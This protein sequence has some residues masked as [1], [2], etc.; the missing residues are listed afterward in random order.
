MSKF[1]KN[2]V[3]IEAFQFT[4]EA[5][6]RVF[7]FVTCSTAA[8]FEDNQPI[9]KIQTPDGVVTARL[10]DWVIKEET[11]EFS[12]CQDQVFQQTYEPVGG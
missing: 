10:G 5:K 2:A 7:H 11:G 9:L 1:R 3:V 12:L 6:D 8:S 4:D